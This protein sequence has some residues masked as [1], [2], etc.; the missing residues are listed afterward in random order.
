MGYDSKSTVQKPHW[1]HVKDIG[2]RLR[3]T[4]GKPE[5]EQW[6]Q[7]IRD[8]AELAVSE[9]LPVLTF[10]AFR[11]FGDTGG[12]EQYERIYFDRRGRIGALAMMV[13]LDSPSAQ[14]GRTVQEWAQGEHSLSDNN[15]KQQR[16]REDSL[17]HKNGREEVSPSPVYIHT[18]EEA[19]WDLCGEY[20]WCLNAHLPAESPY[21]VWEELDLFAAETAGMLAELTV[22]LNGKVDH[23]IIQRMRDEVQRR[24]L[25]PAADPS[26]TFGWETAEHNWSAVCGAGCG[27][28]ALLLLEQPAQTQVLERMTRSAAHFLNGYGE[29]GGCAEGLGYWVYGFGYYTYFMDMLS[30]AGLDKQQTMNDP[31]INAIAAFPEYMH[32]SAG[33]FVNFSDSGEEEI[34][35]PG[36]LSRLTELTGKPYSLPFVMPALREDPCRRWGH[37]LRNIL[38]A[39]PRFFAVPGAIDTDRSMSEA[40]KVTAWDEAQTEA[41]YHGSGGEIPGADAQEDHEHGRLFNHYWHDLCWLISRGELHMQTEYNMTSRETADTGDKAA[42]TTI[43]APISELEVSTTEVHIS[44]STVSTTAGYPSESTD[45]EKAMYIAQ[46]SI[47]SHKFTA[48]LATKGGHNDEP[49]NHNDLGSFIVH[50]GGENIFCDL[51]AGMYTQSYFA[52]GREQILNISSAGHSLPQ[53]NGCE[54]YSG[55]A[56]AAIVELVQT[57][58]H[59]VKFGLDLTAAYPAAAGLKRMN[60]NFHWKINDNK[61]EIN[62]YLQDHFQFAQLS[63]ESSQYDMSIYKETEYHTQNLPKTITENTTSN[64]KAA[65]MM[66]INGAEELIDMKN[67]IDPMDTKSTTTTMYTTGKANPLANELQ[68]GE[69]RLVSQFNNMDE[70]TKRTTVNQ[71]IERLIS[72]VRPVVH[73]HELIWTGK[74]AE[75]RLQIPEEQYNVKV[76]TIDHYD[77]DGRPIVVYRTSLTVRKKWMI[78]LP[79]QELH[80]NLE[81]AIRPLL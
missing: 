62:L 54:Q 64:T 19:L 48:A 14:N 39:E 45:H 78:E 77:H 20:T 13:L 34:L 3:Y 28:A 26:R 40:A 16:K 36:L 73:A 67:T 55:R 27:I 22:L 69:E 76:E 5:Y 74:W 58:D 2:E 57:G 59:E 47:M 8:Y 21:P 11:E 42:F 29:D 18:L 35:P 41:V 56:A 81:F 17:L 51:G 38:W 31:K 63:S 4:A 50:A 25:L 46:S 15:R 68:A 6:W 60:R 71:V 70:N 32:L 52:P 30:A 53:I 23:R 12:R 80:C 43:E 61:Q 44:G 1:W 79:M 72:H 9:P 65:K 33:K 66:T 7:D 24:V 37:L 10:E 49:H 75:I